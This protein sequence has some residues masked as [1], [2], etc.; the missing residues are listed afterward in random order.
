MLLLPT[1]FLLPM[2]V[3]PFRLTL[4][5][6]VLFLIVEVFLLGVALFDVDALFVIFFC[7]PLID[8]LAGLVAALF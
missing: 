4:L 2:L 1:R 5:S 7:P 6:V 8:L 3:L